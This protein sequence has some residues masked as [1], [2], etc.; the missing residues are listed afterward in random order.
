MPDDR[1]HIHAI[2]IKGPSFE[3]YIDNT[4]KDIKE[5]IMGADIPEN[6][7]RHFLDTI[8]ILAHSAKDGAEWNVDF[9]FRPESAIPKHSTEEELEAA[10]F[11]AQ[12]M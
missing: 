10:Y 3:E 2:N 5:I 7:K 8:W 1:N 6:D 9:G 11:T 4:L 12:E